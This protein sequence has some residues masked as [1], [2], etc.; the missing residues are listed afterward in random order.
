LSALGII[1]GSG[2]YE[3]DLANRKEETVTTPFGA[4][5]DALVSGDIGGTRLIFLPRHGRGHRL[6]PHEINYRANVWALKAA[7]AARIVSVSAVGSMLEDIRPGDLVVPDQFI[8]LTRRRESTFFGNGLSGHVAMAD[9]VC[10]ALASQ[11]HATAIGEQPRT[12]QGGAY[13][14]IEGPQFSTRAESRIYRQWGAAVIG[15]TNMPEAKLAREAGLCYA[16]LALATDYDCWHASEED[17]SIAAILAVMQKNVAVA[18]RIV[19][20]LA[21][22][23]AHTGCL[24]AEAPRQAVV[25][26]DEVAPISAREVLAFLKGN[27][28]VE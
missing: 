5:S 25:S 22:Q 2:L 9:P 11:L 21:A 3:L 14:C 18:R 28:G 10:G 26:S 17:V 13:V 7:G 24:C 8:D 4:P 19:C 23:T 12:H 16:T 15:M 27:V 20:A 6:L 1:G